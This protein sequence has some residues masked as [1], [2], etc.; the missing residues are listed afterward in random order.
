MTASIYNVPVITSDDTSA[1]G[2]ALTCVTMIRDWCSYETRHLVT[3]VKPFLLGSAFTS[4]VTTKQ[5]ALC[6]NDNVDMA[7]ATYCAYVT[8]MYAESLINSGK[9][10]IVPRCVDGSDTA[11]VV[12]RG[13]DT[14]KYS[15]YAIALVNDPRGGESTDINSVY[16]TPL[17]NLFSDNVSFIAVTP[18]IHN[19]ASVRATWNSILTQAYT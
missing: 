3:D 8:L 19:T 13:I 4:E 15:G 1:F 7:I 14:D 17:H 12:V 18:D 6:I 11:Y 10:L 9:C 2:T 5:L 16:T